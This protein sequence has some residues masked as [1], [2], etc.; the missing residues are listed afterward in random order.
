MKVLRKVFATIISFIV[1]VIG[2]SFLSYLADI[3]FLNKIF[4]KKDKDGEVRKK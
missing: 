1:D 4:Y 2:G 3:T